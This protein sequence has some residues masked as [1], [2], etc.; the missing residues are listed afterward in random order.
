MVTSLISLLL[1]CLFHF[2][3][4][5]LYASLDPWVPES[6]LW[7]HSLLRLPLQAFINEINEVRLTV[8]ALHHLRQVLR[9]DVAQLS[10]RVGCLDRSIIVVKEYLP[11]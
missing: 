4:Q 11:P 1:R 5:F 3:F 9:V 6:I 8:F 2:L 10:F 7:R